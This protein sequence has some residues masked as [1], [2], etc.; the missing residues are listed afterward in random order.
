MM[1]TFKSRLSFGISEGAPSKLRDLRSLFQSGDS[2]S[3]SNFLKKR[4]GLKVRG[5]IVPAKHPVL[6]VTCC[7]CFEKRRSKT[8]RVWPVSRMKEYGAKIK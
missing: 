1:G 5:K 4:G 2:E 7:Y 3:V 8:L 6:L